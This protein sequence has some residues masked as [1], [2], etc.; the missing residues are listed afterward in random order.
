MSLLLTLL[1]A[2]YVVTSRLDYC[3]SLLYNTSQG[4]LTKLQRVQNNLA[5]VVAGSRR[6]DHIMPVLFDLHWLPISKRIDYKTA[7]ITLRAYHEGAPQY[8]SD[9]VCKYQ[10]TRNLRSTSQSR[11]VV[12]KGL[13]SDTGSQSFSV[14]AAAV[15]NNLPV[16]LRSVT[17]L[18]TFKN[19]LKTHYF[20][21]YYGRS[22][23]ATSE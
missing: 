22:G 19:K 14:G 23:P 16:E 5:R 8:L 9:L 20:N 3:N 17:E 1:L 4:N 6:R 21:D 18:K 15:W 12:P 10:P 13:S 2:A 11:V 7:T